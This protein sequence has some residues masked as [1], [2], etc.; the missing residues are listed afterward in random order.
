V[1]NAKQFIHLLR[2]VVRGKGFSVAALLLV[3][4][5]TPL[6]AGEPFVKLAMDKPSGINFAA[7]PLDLSPTA[8]KPV[9][10]STDCQFESQPDS[11]QPES[12]PLVRTGSHSNKP[13][14]IQAGYGR[15]WDD[16]STLQKICADHQEHGCAY[17]SARF[18]F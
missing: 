3:L 4:A 14:T 15:I 10:L 5:A 1:Q 9:A 8:G 6:R 12:F 7:K 11:D 13:V 2:L 17:V 16:Q 18:S